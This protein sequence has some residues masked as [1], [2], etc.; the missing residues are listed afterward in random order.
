MESSGVMVR[1]QP[2]DSARVTKRQYVFVSLAGTIGLFI[3][4]VVWVYDGYEE[5]AGTGRSETTADALF[6]VVTSIALIAWIRR[7]RRRQDDGPRE[8][9]IAWGL[10]TVLIV[11]TAIEVARFYSI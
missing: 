5:D 8:V 2:A 11:G 6:F 10:T 3:G 9:M 4:L 1:E 7:M